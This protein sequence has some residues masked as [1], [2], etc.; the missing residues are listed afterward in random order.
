MVLYQSTT[1]TPAPNWVLICVAFADAG[2]Q[3]IRWQAG[4]VVL[5]IPG[6]GQQ[7]QW[8]GTLQQLGR[9]ASK[10]VLNGVAGSVSVPGVLTA[11][12]AW[13]TTGGG[14]TAYGRSPAPARSM[15]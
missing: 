12:E 14:G 4:S 15:L 7:L 9:G 10:I 13:V 11:Q 2:Q 3:V 8:S 5:P 6:S 1:E